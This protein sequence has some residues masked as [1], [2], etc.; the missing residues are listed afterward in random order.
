MWGVLKTLVSGASTRAEEQL[1]SAYSLELI[2][3][4]IKEAED[5][6]KAAKQSLASLIQRL[7]VEERQVE[8][9][10]VKKKD[11][12][13]RAQ[14]A[15]ANDRHDLA[16]EAAQAVADME[17]ELRIR[18]ETLEKLQAKS[19]R[20]RQT[21]EKSNRRI[22]DLKQGE[23]QARAVRREH[24]AQR[25]L[26]KHIKSESAADE[27][28]ELIANVLNEDDPFEQSEILRE[29]DQDL[30]HDT[31]AD[32]MASEGFGKQTKT[33]ASDILEQLKADQ[34]PSKS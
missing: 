16:S 11:L 1:K 33:T 19:V 30:D 24:E 6:H 18:S 14:S 20:L 22:I 27:A 10:N 13:E 15:L 17:N 23:I 32:R 7:R 31:L 28:A 4:K 3:Q 34:P 5:A 8:T 26:N 25:K 29:I 21:L 12:L 2:A 9:L